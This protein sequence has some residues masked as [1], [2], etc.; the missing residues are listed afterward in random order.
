MLMLSVAFQA[1]SVLRMLSEY[2]GEDKFLKGVSI[3]LKKHLFSNSVT[4]DLWQGIQEASGTLTCFCASVTRV[5]TSRRHRCTKNDGQ[6]GQK[7]TWQ[8]VDVAVNAHEY[9]DGLPCHQSYRDEGRY[10]YPPG[11]LL[12]DRSCG[13]QRQ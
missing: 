11:P 12:G 8:V 7:G 10:P 2:V 3:Y 5:V 9:V 1:A 6:L 4:K 13:P